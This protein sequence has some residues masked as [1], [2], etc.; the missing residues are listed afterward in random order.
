MLGD[1]VEEFLQLLFRLRKILFQLVENRTHGVESMSRYRRLRG[2]QQS[3]GIVF[4]CGQHLHDIAQAEEMDLLA[5]ATRARFRQTVRLVEN[6]VI[7]RSQKGEV[8]G[9]VTQEKTMAD[10]RHMRVIGL[11]FGRGGES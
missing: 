2:G 4:G 3:A 8:L 5:Q 1:F 9:E 7:E 6:D 11:G 10:Y